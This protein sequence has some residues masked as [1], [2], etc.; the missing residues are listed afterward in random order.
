MVLD[1]LGMYERLRDSGHFED[2]QAHALAE[3][4]GKAFTDPNVDPEAL[5]QRFCDAGF[6]EE[7]SASLASFFADLAAD[8][9]EYWKMSPPK[10][11]R[12]SGELLP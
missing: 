12:I 1:T 10:L 5:R 3:A 4:T 7:Q 2:D 8:L 9:P 11:R 6:P